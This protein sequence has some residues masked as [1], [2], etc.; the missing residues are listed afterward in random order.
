MQNTLVVF[1][2]NGNW[3]VD[4]KNTPEAA[5]IARMFGGTTVLP[6][7]Y[8]PLVAASEVMARVKKLNPQYKVVAAAGNGIT[9]YRPEKFSNRAG[10]FVPTPEAK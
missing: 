3:M 1:D 9:H 8:T 4:W 6:T 5:K 7:P 10:S 2:A